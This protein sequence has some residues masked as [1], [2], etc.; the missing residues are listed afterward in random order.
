MG[1]RRDRIAVPSADHTMFSS[2]VRLLDHLSH[3]AT[4]SMVMRIAWPN[5]ALSIEESGSPI[6][7]LGN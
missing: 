5:L 4:I 3:T 7:R 2:Q 1:R 6:C